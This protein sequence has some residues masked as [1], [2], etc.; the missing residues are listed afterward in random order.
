MSTSCRSDEIPIQ[1]FALRVSRIPEADETSRI[2]GAL[3]ERARTL[4]ARAA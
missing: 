4:L 2:I 3:V 1:A